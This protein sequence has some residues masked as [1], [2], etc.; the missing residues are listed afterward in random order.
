MT[1]WGLI[2]TKL[3]C[4]PTCIFKKSPWS[5]SEN[6]LKFRICSGSSYFTFFGHQALG[7]EM[8]TKVSHSRGP[9]W[10]LQYPGKWSS[11]FCA[12]QPHSAAFSFLHLALPSLIVKLVAGIV[13]VITINWYSK[14]IVTGL[15]H[16]WESFADRLRSWSPFLKSHLMTS[17]TLPGLCRHF[18]FCSH[19]AA[20]IKHFL[21]NSFV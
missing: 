1:S 16:N 5:P 12:A 6:E 10:T 14:I 11:S 17:E 21:E 7:D 8:S 2:Q 15:C 3:S 18:H 19:N 9:C 13:I 4:D 20:S